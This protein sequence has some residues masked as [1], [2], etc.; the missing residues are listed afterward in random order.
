MY[1]IHIAN[2]L[3]FIIHR[4]AD[5]DRQQ[6]QTTTTTK[7]ERQ[8]IIKIHGRTEYPNILEKYTRTY[9]FKHIEPL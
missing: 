5:R 1:I 2:I 6:Q 4:T 9:A 8:L 7:K 3:L